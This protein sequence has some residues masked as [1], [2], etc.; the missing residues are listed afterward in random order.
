MTKTELTKAIADVVGIPQSDVR[1]V[2]KAM[3]T[4]ITNQLAKGEKVALP[5]IGTLKTQHR[6]ARP[7][8]NPKTGE[9][10][11]VPE[12]RAIKLTVST[13]LKATIQ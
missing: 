12:R 13:S 4:I 9:S 2:F 10:A 1:D 7:A 3:E 11:M 5:G 6:K 8:R